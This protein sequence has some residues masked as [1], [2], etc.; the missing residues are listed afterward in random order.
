M[1]VAELFVGSVEDNFVTVS[2]LN[3]EVRWLTDSSSKC[4]KLLFHAVTPKRGKVAGLSSAVLASSGVLPV[5][6]RVPGSIL[7]RPRGLTFTFDGD[8][9]VYVFNR[10]QPSLPAPFYSVLVSV[11]VF[12]A[13]SPVFHCINSRENSSFSHSVL[14]VLFLPYWSF[15]LYISLWKCLSALV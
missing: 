4:T 15:Q 7:S 12:M 5:P 10:H 1:C 13:R 6:A 9:A 11:S 2:S 8:V 3:W 14:P